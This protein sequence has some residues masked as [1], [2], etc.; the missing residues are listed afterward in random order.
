MTANWT[1]GS[2]MSSSISSETDPSGGPGKTIR[3]PFSHNGKT[4]LSR[5]PSGQAERIAENLN[6]TEKTLYLCP[7]PVY[8][9]GLSSLLKKIKNNSAILCI[10]ADKE[11]YELSIN[12]LKQ[13][14][15]DKRLLL[16]KPDPNAP[17]QAAAELCALVNKTWGS[18]TFR[19]VE[20]IRL[21]G[22]WQLFPELY[23]KIT[24]ALREEIAVSWSN[25]MTLIRLGRLYI[26]NTIRNL[27]LLRDTQDEASQNGQAGH[28]FSDISALDFGADPVLVLGA[29]PGMDIM[30]DELTNTFV[31][32]GFTG[33]RP[34]RIIC[35]DTCLPSLKERGVKPDLA[36]VL[37]SQHWNLRDFLNV[38][39]W[40]VQAAIDLSALPASVKILGGG[41]FFFMTPWTNLSLFSRLEQSGLLP[42]ALTPL[43]SVGLTAT[44]L[45]LRISR[46]PVVTAGIDFSFTIDA[47]HARSSPGHLARLAAA[48]RFKSLLNAETAFRD[49][50]FTTISK[51]GNPVRSD[52]A[53]RNYRDMFENEFSSEDRIYEMEGPGLSLGINKLNPEQAVRLLTMNAAVPVNF[54]KPRN[55]TIP[56]DLLTVRKSNHQ[57][58]T[59]D[60][61]S[62]FQKEINYLLKLRSVLTGEITVQ[63]VDLD[64]LLDTC[65]Y[66]YAHFPEC[67]AVS[68]R[69][70]CTDI[71]FLKRVRMEIDPFLKLWN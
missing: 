33:T 37:E 48:N 11:L 61:E 6:V 24:A 64:E 1:T 45:A 56:N 4:I 55:E 54:K 9:Y 32:C 15:E 52:P 59:T 23:E 10:E 27:A 20:V 16:V 29:G 7:S 44:E 2:G 62:F 21:T 71:G 63:P 66:L 19:K 43:G 35:A 46:G 53:L 5:D 17:A 58:E 18:R 41:I 47:Y 40:K 42:P 22:G 12:A 60:I 68:K 31:K 28:S 25:A 49:G 8:G 3:G 67:A 38:R 14:D 51:T 70:P 30:L 50:V 26:R 69:P 36:V 57:S 39:D 34:F 13:F 65:D